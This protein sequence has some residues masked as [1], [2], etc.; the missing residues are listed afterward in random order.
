MFQ[1]TLFTS[2]SNGRRLTDQNF[3]NFM[4]FS[5]KVLQ[6][7][8]SPPR[9]ESWRPSLRRILD[10]PLLFDS[11]TYQWRIMVRKTEDQLERMFSYIP[12]MSVTWG[13]LRC[14]LTELL[15]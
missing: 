3:L 7:D 2:R 13:T 11:R 15:E 14:A 1:S 10:P 6:N 8:A 12:D 9:L 4:G 5:S